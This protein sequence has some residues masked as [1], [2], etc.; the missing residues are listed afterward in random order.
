MIVP[1]T[2]QSCLARSGWQ[3]VE[4]GLWTRHGLLLTVRDHRTVTQLTVTRPTPTCL[5]GPNYRAGTVTLDLWFTPR[6]T[7]HAFQLLEANT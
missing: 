2:L 6:E 7:G 5:D 4:P 1:V 3:P